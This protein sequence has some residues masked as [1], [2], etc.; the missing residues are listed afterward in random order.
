MGALALWWGLA[1]PA[2]AQGPGAADTLL[3]LAAAV[4]LALEYYPSVRAARAGE[5]GAAAR[6]GQA[7]AAWWPSFTADGSLV[8]FQKQ[9][10]VFPIHE[11]SQDAFVFDRTLVQ[12]AL[13]L[14]WTL[15]DGFGR[16]ARVKGARAHERAAEA[17]VASA[18]MGLI[19]EV[20][21]AYLEVLS[22][23]GTLDAQLQ[24]L[25]AL[26]AERD[27]I[28]QLLAQGQAAR[29]ERLRV[30]AAYAETEAE[31]IATAARLD[32]AERR[33]ARL[34]GIDVEAARAA[35]LVP[36]RLA[37][38]RHT[39]ERTVLLQRF[40]AAN[41]ELQEALGLTEAADQGR[42]AAAAA[43]WPRLDVAGAYLLFGSKE[44]EFQGEWQVGLRL[45][46][47]LF[48]GGQRSR[49]V[50]EAGA[51]AEEA[52]A[53]YELARLRGHEV[54]DRALA[55][56]EE[57]RARVEAIATAVEHLVEVARIERLALEAGRGT[58][59]DYLGAEAS[60][61]RARASLVQARHAE[62]AARVELGRVAGELTPSWLSAMLETVP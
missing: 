37:H 44:F 3:T 16:S 49:A 59:T 56:V 35:R 34:L 46:Y 2:Q 43:W 41:P 31:R 13:Q 17:R 8:R 42:R 52:R 47:P 54:V 32:T 27:R 29:V 55:A 60:L 30:D 40:E 58:Q 22:A 6:A 53:Q 18:Q 1:S 11:L 15:F 5:T 33:L 12:G 48:T 20:T 39:E 51:Q 14:G 45:S 9:M 57:Q 23:R 21:V 28:E 38:T 4:D 19:S 62:I 50:S 25:A 26:A 36:V 24:S 61:R 7:S 10:L